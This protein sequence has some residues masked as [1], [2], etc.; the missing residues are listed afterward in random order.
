MNYLRPVDYY[1][2]DPDALLTE[3]KRKLKAAAGR[4]RE[5]SRL[6]GLTTTGS[7]VYRFSK[8]DLSEND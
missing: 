8:V 1:R 2:G 5:V 7:G 6:N 3:Q 4:Q